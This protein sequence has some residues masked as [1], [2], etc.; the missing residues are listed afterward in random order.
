MLWTDAKLGGEDLIGTL[1]RRSEGRRRWEAAV[2][3]LIGLNI[4]LVDPEEQPVRQQQLKLDDTFQKHMRR[5][6]NGG[7]APAFTSAEAVADDGAEMRKL[8]LALKMSRSSE[9]YSQ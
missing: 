5:A 4:L 6:I 7:C 2:A 3:E 1:A 8:R 9:V